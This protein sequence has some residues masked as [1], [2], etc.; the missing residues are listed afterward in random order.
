MGFRRLSHLIKYKK[1]N[2]IQTNM[3]LTENKLNIEY[4][5]F[6][7]WLSLYCKVRYLRLPDS[8]QTVK[9]S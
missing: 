2:S 1:K 7:N 9:A 8:G 3:A 6:S 4:Y 5:I